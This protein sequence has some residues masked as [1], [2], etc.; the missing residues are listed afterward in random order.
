MTNSRELAEQAFALLQDALEESEAQRSVLEARLQQQR[1]AETEPERQLRELAEQLASTEQERA[2]WH[3][4]AN[5]LHDVVANERAKNKRLVDRLETAESGT[6][7]S[8]RKEVNYWRQKAEE[9]GSTKQQFQQRIFALKAELVAAEE[10]FETL[11]RQPSNEGEIQRLQTLLGER[12]QQ[13]SELAAAFEG[14]KLRCSELTERIADQTKE[15]EQLEN[16][17]RELE[18][19]GLA[20]QEAQNQLQHEL[21]TLRAE[22]EADVQAKTALERQVAEA[23]AEKDATTREVDALRQQLDE[24]QDTSDASRDTIE[25]LEHDLEELRQQFAEAQEST[26]ANRDSL[27]SLQQEI[28]D[29]RADGSTKQAAIDT[30]QRQLAETQELSQERQQT[31]DTLHRELEELRSLDDSK[32]QEITA[33][34]QQVDDLQAH[35]ASDEDEIRSLRQDLAES[36]KALSASREQMAGLEEELREEK[37]RSEDFNVMADDR[38]A[39]ITKLTEKLEETQER[40]EDTKWHLG[41][42]KHFEKLVRRRKKLIRDLLA[43]IRAKQKASNALKAGLDSLRRY[44]AN[45]DQKQQELLRRI[46]TLEQSLSE[47]REKLGKTQNTKR[48]ADQAPEM[49][50][51]TAR[52]RTQLA[53]QT[54]VI[55]SLEQDLKRTRLAEAEMRSKTMEV[56]R[57]SDDIATK[58]TFIGS[59][60]K[61]IEEHQR[62]Q[63]LLRKREIELREIGEQLAASNQKLAELEKEN[64]ALRAARPGEGGSIDRDKVAEL[65]KRIGH[66]SHQLKQYE[67]T[68]SKLNQ[69]VDRW[70][71]KY[72]FLAADPPYGLDSA[73]GG[74]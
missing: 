66:M 50:T 49:P 48:S 37:V 34:Q 74:K 40:Y 3:K 2:Q 30:L 39:Q 11:G 25:S 72:E 54:E 70:K 58:N 27:E 12:E 42:A 9:F 61:D 22:H 24:S 29:A 13:I 7:K 63:A 53:A 28:A 23:I 15:R 56:E 69:D 1:P 14:S 41:K 10:R 44:K 62:V 31:I 46:E 16:R 36:T 26:D 68:I 67:S 64:E 38:R 5:Q 60:Q 65:E 43:H 57:L 20:A 45:A 18:S 55:R 51:E 8:L 71:R 21:A 35:R 6:D 52:L 32:Q 59:L 17:R 19:S 4:T 73:T 47:A 33:I